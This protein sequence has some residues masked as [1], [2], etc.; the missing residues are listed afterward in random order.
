MLVNNLIKFRNIPILKKFIYRILLNK[1]IDLPNS[2][3]IGKNV[4]FPHNSIGTVIH[5]N[6]LINDN[7]KIYQNVTIGRADI[8]IKSKY[9]KFKKI[10]LDDGCVI[11]SGAKVLCKNGTLIVG[12]NT[13]IAAN[14]VLTQSTGENEIWGGIPAKKIRNL[15]RKELDEKDINN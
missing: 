11:C 3:Q 8:Y 7:V 2:V 14:S 9:S 12:K 4:K 10:I 5:N 1:G 6:C 13:V 15:T